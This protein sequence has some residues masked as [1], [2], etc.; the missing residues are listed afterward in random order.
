VDSHS[1]SRLKTLVNTNTLWGEG[2]EE[3]RGREGE[4]EGEGG[5]EGGNIKK[6]KTKVCLMKCHVV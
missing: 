5:R 6:P 4:R 1:D 2:R 3:E